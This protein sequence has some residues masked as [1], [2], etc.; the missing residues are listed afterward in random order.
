[1]LAIGLLTLGSTPDT[2]FPTM[3]QVD[4]GAA[5]RLQ[6]RQPCRIHTGFP[7]IANLDL[8]RLE[9]ERTC[10]GPVKNQGRI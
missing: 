4:L 5:P 2:P 3:V 7:C 1:M 10:P 8:F 9:K 6:W